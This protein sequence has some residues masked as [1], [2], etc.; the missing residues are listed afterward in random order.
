MSEKINPGENQPKEK[1]YVIGK[2]Y[3]EGSE[4][5]YP[6]GYRAMAPR[7]YW[8]PILDEIYKYA[9]AQEPSRK[10]VVADVGC[11]YGYLLKHLQELDI[12]THKVGTD[13]SRYALKKAKHNVSDKTLLIEHN[14][15][16]GFPFGDQIFDIVV[17][18]DVVEHTNNRP[19]TITELARSLKSGG[20]LI[21]SV[22]VKDTWAGKFVWQLDKDP[23]HVSVP[24]TEEILTEITAAGLKII[25]TN[26][27]WPLFALR[28]PIPT[29]IEI[30]AQ[31][32]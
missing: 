14:L 4:S 21:I 20:L 18:G 1:R 13:I 2:D 23:T 27:F 15:N 30:V 7:I 19:Q 6:M 32:S 3:F 26:N 16:E 11:A 25:K 12:D 8:K 10:L 28:V 24:T 17:A 9:K 5:N 31:K 22:P 29:N